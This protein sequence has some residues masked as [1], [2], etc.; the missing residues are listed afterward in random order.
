LAV[1][2][3]QKNAATLHTLDAEKKYAGG[4]AINT[5]RI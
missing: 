2:I 1:L 3:L 4:I 5:S